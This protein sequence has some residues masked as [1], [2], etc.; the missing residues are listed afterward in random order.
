NAGVAPD[1]I[2]VVCAENL[3]TTWEPQVP[4]SAN[5]SYGLGWFVDEYK[6]QL[7]IQHG[8]NTLGFSSD[9][10]F[11]PHA[12]IGISVLTN[13]QISD[14]FNEAVRFRLLELVFEQ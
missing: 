10:A 1:G 12:G 8:G 7:M 11:L 14:A 13:A 5:S 3:A 9:L 6:G 4:I 2:Q